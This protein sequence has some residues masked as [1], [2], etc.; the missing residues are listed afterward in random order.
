MPDKFKPT[1]RTM[2]YR[3]ALL[4]EL[5]A[6]QKSLASAN[7]PK[8]RIR[9][10]HHPAPMNSFSVEERVEDFHARLPNLFRRIQF[11]NY[12]A[13]AYEIGRIWGIVSGMR[14]CES[15]NRRLNRSR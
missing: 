9:P 2:H 1:M 12:A 4:Y 15:K 10:P 5:R 13:T 7:V 3:A 14:S 8:V 6:L 11:R